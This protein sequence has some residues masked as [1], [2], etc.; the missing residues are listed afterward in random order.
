[1]NAVTSFVGSSAAT[2]AIRTDSMSN[3]SSLAS[4]GARDICEREIGRRLRDPGESDKSLVLKHVRGHAGHAGNEAA[5]AVATA[6]TKHKRMLDWGNK[7]ACFGV[8]RAP[9]QAWAVGG[10]V[11]PCGSRV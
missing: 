3:L 9:Q 2:G 4:A 5:D 7:A 10:L 8:A 11:C 1:M 6:I